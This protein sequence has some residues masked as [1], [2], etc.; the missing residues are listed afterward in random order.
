MP[1][2][3]SVMRYFV[4]VIAMTYC[5]AAKLF[6][7][8]LVTFLSVN[9]NIHYIRRSAAAGPRAISLELGGKSPLL[10]FPDADLDA[11]IDWIMTGILWGSGQV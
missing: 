11:A 10:L 5:C 6:T 4:C 8:G 9:D 7:M 3:Q 2:A 1:T